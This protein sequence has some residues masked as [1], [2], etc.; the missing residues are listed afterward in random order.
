M[1]TVFLNS[2]Y[3]PKVLDRTS[4]WQKSMR[5]AVSHQGNQACGPPNRIHHSLSCCYPLFALVPKP[6]T[7]CQ[8][9]GASKL[10]SVAEGTQPARRCKKDLV[11][12]HR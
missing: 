4:R 5:Q 12:E 10:H 8:F 11:A 2:S 3:W 7:S 9:R 6:P 1:Q